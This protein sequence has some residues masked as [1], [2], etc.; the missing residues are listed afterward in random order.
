M[1]SLSETTPQLRTQVY[2]V[3]IYPKKGRKERRRGGG[4]RKEKKGRKKGRRI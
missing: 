1:S 4:K 3:S 2:I